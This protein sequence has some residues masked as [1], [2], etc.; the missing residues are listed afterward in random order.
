MSDTQFDDILYCF[1][2]SVNFASFSIHCLGGGSGFSPLLPVL[3]DICL[4]F[5]K[6]PFNT[7]FKHFMYIMLLYVWCGNAIQV[8]VEVR[9][10]F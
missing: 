8:A 7:N 4:W 10:I 6:Y 5:L 1:F 3:C 2:F 9:G